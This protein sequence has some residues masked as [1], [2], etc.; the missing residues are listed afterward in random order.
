MQLQGRLRSRAEEEE[1]LRKE[2]RGTTP[3]IKWEIKPVPKPLQPKEEEA[4]NLDE[5]NKARLELQRALE[6]AP[7]KP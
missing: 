2:I 7:K 1:Q 5:L 6:N 3:Q 4:R